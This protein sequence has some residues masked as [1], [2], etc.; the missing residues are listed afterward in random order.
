M[1]KACNR[2]KERN[3][4]FQRQL[5]TPSLLSF[6]GHS[7]DCAQQSTNPNLYLPWRLWHG[8]KAK[9]TLRRTPPGLICVGTFLWSSQ[10]SSGQLTTA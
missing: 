7:R 3:K 9:V 10:S 6:F 4:D 2:F 8:N 1:K 5:A